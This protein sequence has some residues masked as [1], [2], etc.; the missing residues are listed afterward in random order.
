MNK[1]S[2]ATLEKYK[3]KLRVE[4]Y[5]ERTIRMY[6][7]YV[8]LFLSNFDKDFYH[9]S[10]KEAIEFL[11]SIEYSSIS[12]QNQYIS[13]VKL[14]YKMIGKGILVVKV[15]RP[16]KEKR[17]PRVIDKDF[18]ISRINSITNKKHKAI[19]SLAYSVGLR[20]SEVVNLRVSD[21]DGTRGVINIRQSKGRKDRVVPLSDNLRQILREYYKE[22]RPKD[23]L[24]SG[25]NNSKYSVSSCGKLVKNYLGE[26]K[27]FHL[28]RHS[29]LTSMLEGGTDLRTI[30]SI[31]GHSKVDTTSI[32]LH[33]S[34]QHLKQA[35]LPI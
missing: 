11:E 21:I 14:L 15:S 8:Y 24:F 34:T 16:R 26:D 4:N 30:Q 5:S 27:H 25:Q 12:V 22:Y 35:V 33:I 23:Y 1:K 20:V 17:L 28:L 31:A 10:Q 6:V 32:Y 18:L 3:Q 7:H 19:L 29:S 9:I 13:S 2:K